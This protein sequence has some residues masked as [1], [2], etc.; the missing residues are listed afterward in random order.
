MTNLKRTL[1]LFLLAAVCL[2]AV[3]GGASALEGYAGFRDEKDIQHTEAVSAMVA[4]GVLNGKGDGSWFDPAGTV[5][6]AEMAK[7]ISFCLNGG[8]DTGDGNSVLYVKFSDVALG[9][10]A[11]KYISECV[12]RGIIAGRGDGTF[13]PEDPV[14]GTQA[15]KMLLCALGYDPDRAGLEGGD[16]AVNTDNWA[17]FAGLYRGL[18]DI[19]VAMSLSREHAAQMA[20]NALSAHMV[21]YDV[22]SVEEIENI[23]LYSEQLWWVADDG[24]YTFW[25][26]SN[27]DGGNRLVMV[28]LDPLLLTAFGLSQFPEGSSG[29][30]LAEGESMLQLTAQVGR[31]EDEGGDADA[32]VQLLSGI[33]WIEQVSRTPDGGVCCATSF[34]VTGV[35]SPY[36]EAY[37]SSGG[38]VGHGAV[39]TT[40][41]GAEGNTA[42]S[43][44]DSSEYPIHKIA[45]LCPYASQ[46]ASFKLE[47]YSQFTR[48]MADYL[49]DCTVEYY[50]DSAVDLEL[51]KSLDQFDMVFF[52]SHGTLSNITNSAWDIFD[53]KPYTMTGEFADSSAAYVFLEDDF[54]SGRTVVDLSDGRIGVG[55]SFYQYYYGE[56]QLEG[57]FFHFASC[58][59]MKTD[60]LADGLLSRGAAW[61]EGWSS[62]VTFSNDYAQV[63]G[64]VFYLLEG[65]TIARSIAL[66]DDTQLALPTLQSDCTMVGKGDESYRIALPAEPE[67]EIC[68]TGTVVDEETEAAL[69]GADVRV[70]DEESGVCHAA[71]T[72]E[73]GAFAVELDRPSGAMTLEVVKAGYETYART[74]AE[75]T[76]PDMGTV[77]LAPAGGT[78]QET[79]AIDWHWRV[80]DGD[81]GLPLEGVKVYLYRRALD[82]GPAI[83]GE[84]LELFEVLETDETGETA[85]VSLTVGYEY[86]II[87]EKEGYEIEPKYCGRWDDLYGLRESMYIIS[88]NLLQMYRVDA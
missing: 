20:Y 85:V 70:Y 81:T 69:A 86:G 50:Y 39:P 42:L 15:A 49:P 22:L 17:D 84:G 21:G 3:L 34:G 68:V 88:G 65:E 40:A 28:E 31:L 67:Q 23:D 12:Q 44:V 32:V 64:V 60:A 55:G 38:G 74:M 83:T 78:S 79:Q 19:P 52:Y 27:L 72:D 46:D 14:T 5:T 82:D 11:A 56:N 76:S 16:W 54:L 45:V 8:K 6:R 41:S 62:N 25:E 18:D 29:I 53:S 33:D 75:G 59:S 10:W 58:C 24:S 30:T 9:H 57:T 80:E 26:L 61:V 48:A 36:Q 2:T 47:E 71:V 7:I 51:L 35:W 77:R 63:Y 37:I 87:L 4:L 1:S 13:G 66:A 43:A 73:N